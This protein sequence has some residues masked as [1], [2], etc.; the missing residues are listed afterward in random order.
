ML[1]TVGVAERLRRQVVALEI[2]GSNPSVHP[3][4]SQRDSIL[5]KHSFASIPFAAL[6]VAALALTLAACGGG[7]SDQTSRIVDRLLTSGQ[8]EDTQVQTFVGEMPADLPWELPR[9]PG[10]EVLA[11]FVLEQTGSSAYFIML[12]SDD[13]S[14]EIL[15]FYEGALNEDP[16]QVEGSTSSTQTMALQ[17]SKV[18]DANVTGGMAV[19]SLPEGGSGIVVSVEQA[20]EASASAEPFKLEASRPLPPNFPSDVPLYPDSTVTETTWLRS[21]GGVDFLV[22]FLTTDAQEDVMGFYREDFSGRGFTVTDEESSGFELT[23]S[24]T[25]PA[26]GELSGSVT[27]DTF[28]EDAAYTQVS[29]QVHVGSAQGDGN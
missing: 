23:L 13:A 2:E 25:D 29:L 7:D 12:D 9:Y 18:D 28:A 17:F 6:A 21:P 14:D 3:I 1:V 10:S 8:V 15:Q 16:W 19:D 20:K 22:T 27:A 11:S 4:L 26:T 24:F 5:L